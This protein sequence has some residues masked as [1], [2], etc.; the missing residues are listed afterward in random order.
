MEWSLEVGG[1]DGRLVV[2]FPTHDAGA[3]WDPYHVEV[4]V[5]VETWGNR[6][7]GGFRASVYGG[8]LFPPVV[9]QLAS[10]LNALLKQLDGTASFGS[11]PYGLECRIELRSGKGS[12]SGKV[13]ST[14]D[15]KNELRFSFSTDQSYLQ[16]TAHQIAALVATFPAD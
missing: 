1:D 13:S 11:D 9:R 10:D 4:V 3:D 8:Y 12:V 5:T 14:L 6:D 2:S 16:A 15:N 7:R